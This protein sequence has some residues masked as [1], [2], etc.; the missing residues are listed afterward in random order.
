[1]VKL[2]FGDKSRTKFLGGKVKVSGEVCAHIT[3]NVCVCVLS[4]FCLIKMRIISRMRSITGLKERK[5]YY[6]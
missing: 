2:C 1:M 4:V 3:K 5:Y 6:L